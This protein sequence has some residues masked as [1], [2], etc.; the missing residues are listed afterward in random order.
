MAPSIDTTASSSIFVCFSPEFLLSGTRKGKYTTEHRTREKSYRQICMTREE[1]FR[2]APRH[3]YNDSI[4]SKRLFESSCQR[5]AKNRNTGGEWK[6][7]GCVAL[8]I[9]SGSIRTLC[10]LQ[11][12]TRSTCSTAAV[13][14]HPKP[15]ARNR[16]RAS[17]S[18]AAVLV[19]S[20]RKKIVIKRKVHSL[21]SGAF[22]CRWCSMNTA[23][24]SAFEGFL[25]FFLLGEASWA[26][27]RL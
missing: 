9:R 12:P 23:K 13:T 4:A 25:S 5:A 26:L 2:M 14:A 27:E 1:R 16:N 10:H 21:R 7:F 11:L 15:P 24:E 8:N 3:S 6:S 19:V 22:D 18:T 17:F 20:S